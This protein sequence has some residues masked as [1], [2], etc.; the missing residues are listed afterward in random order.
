MIRT[1]LGVATFGVLSTNLDIK[2]IE[3]P[4]FSKHKRIIKTDNEIELIKTAMELARGGFVQFQNYLEKDG[5][6]KSEQYLGFLAQTFLSDSGKYDLS[7][8]PIIAINENV[9]KPHAIP[10]EKL[11][12]KDDLLLFDGGIKYQ[13]YCS[14]RTVTFGSTFPNLT[15]TKENKYFHKQ[16]NKKYTI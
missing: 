14:D 10:S 4:N 7:F 1:I 13:R 11:Y 6:G 15:F 12:Q 16:N 2:F 5:F 8:D 3:K 9:A